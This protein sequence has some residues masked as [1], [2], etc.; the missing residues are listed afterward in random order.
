MAKL[1]FGVFYWNRQSGHVSSSA[2]LNVHKNRPLR[3]GYRSAHEA[4]SRA[5]YVRAQ[6]ARRELRRGPNF[7]DAQR[8][9]R[10]PKSFCRARAARNKERPTCRGVKAVETFRDWMI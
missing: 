6:G 4:Q 3:G 2:G 10:D 9:L 7:D 8:S 1:P 5:H